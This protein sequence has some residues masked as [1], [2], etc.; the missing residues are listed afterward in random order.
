MAASEKFEPSGR[1]ALDLEIARHVEAVGGWDYTGEMGVACAVVY[2][3][4][5]QRFRCYDSSELEDLQACVQRAD[6]IVTWNGWTF[7]LPVIYG[8]N[9][10]DWEAHPLKQQP[11]GKDGKPL[12]ERSVDLLRDVYAAQGL[13]PDKRTP[14]HAGWRLED[15][16]LATIGVGKCGEGALAPD[17]FQK[18]RWGEL[19]TYC[20]H[21]VW[22]TKELDLFRRKHRYFLNLRG[23]VVRFK[24]KSA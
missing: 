3:F 23:K 15:C 21:D 10:P 8:V 6:Q 7:D 20:Q 22:L 14:A 4:A 16:S 19:I 2:D 11:G 5:A 18:G 12:A 24:T 13:D 1:I 17:L 9:R